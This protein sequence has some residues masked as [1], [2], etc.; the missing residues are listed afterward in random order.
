MSATPIRQETYLPQGGSEDLAPVHD[1]ITT[2]EAAA[3]GRPAP[4]HFLAGATAGDQVAIPAE[5][6]RILRQ[7]VEALREGLAVTVVPQNTTLTTQQSADLLGISR[8]SL[9]KLLDEGEIPYDRIGTHR[10]IRLRDVL[11]YREHR[12]ALQYAALDETAVNLD[13][14][15]DLEI[16]LERLREARRAAAARRRKPAST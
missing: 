15:G 10:R 6:Y 11:A 7:V 2:H 9:I 12:R 16:E 8:P 3:I 13:D 5:V 4:R 14:E 1:F